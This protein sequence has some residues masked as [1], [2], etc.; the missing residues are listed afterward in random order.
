MMIREAA[1]VDEPIT[2]T[3]YDP[4]W[5]MLYESERA[6]LVSALRT[7][8]TRIEHFGSTAVPGMAG[9]PIVDLLVG[10]RTMPE[11]SEC[12][13]VLEQLGYENFGEIF[14]PGRVYL[15][16]RG[17]PHFNAAVT[18]EGGA[19]WDA[20]IVLRE[21]LRQHPREASAYSEIKRSTYAS[22]ARLFSTYSQ[23]KQPFLAALQDRAK[24]WHEDQR[25]EPSM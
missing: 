6:R 15:R 5:P 2:V 7:R 22:G 24:R 4:R 16:R 9:K 21:Y 12:T 14:L 20:Q 8:V 23:A 1:D 11:F 10:V 3:D 18:P 25:E 13:Q 19:F 17:P